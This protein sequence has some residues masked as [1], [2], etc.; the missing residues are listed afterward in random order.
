MRFQ[1]LSYFA[2]LIL[3][4]SEAFTAQRPGAL[5]VRS[6]STSLNVGATIDWNPNHKDESF[7]MDRAYH[8]ASSDTCSLDDARTC[9][10]DVLHIQSACVTGDLLGDV[11]ENA[12]TAAEIVATL[13]QR[14][15]DETKRLQ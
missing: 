9:L 2:V 3:P 7:L 4:C 6:T 15:K 8:C 14:I 5:P 12:D 13:R 10:D 11:C 1:Q